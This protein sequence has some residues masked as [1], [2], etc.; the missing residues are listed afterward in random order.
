[1]STVMPEFGDLRRW[2]QKG[3]CASS[4]KGS[5]GTDRSALEHAAKSFVIALILV[6]V[7]QFITISLYAKDTKFD[8]LLGLP[9]FIAPFLVGCALFLGILLICL[10]VTRTQLKMRVA[11]SLTLYVLSGIT[12]ILAIV[13]HEQL[14]E[15]VQLFVSRRDPS[16]SYLRAATIILLKA[17]QASAFAMIRAWVFFLTELAAAIWYLL[18]NL[19]RVLIESSSADLR[20]LRVTTALILALVFNALVNRYYTGRLFWVLLGRLLS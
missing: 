14:S 10:W 15:A 17:D 18:L 19:R 20:G 6:A 12:P 9:L 2:F 3:I 8:E 13:L 7:V 4:L 11:S 1:M 16:L 5:D